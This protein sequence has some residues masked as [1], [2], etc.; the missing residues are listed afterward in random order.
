V[1]WRKDLETIR[2]DAPVT[3]ADDFYRVNYSKF[4]VGMMTLEQ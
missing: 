2:P 1:L 4:G 3:D